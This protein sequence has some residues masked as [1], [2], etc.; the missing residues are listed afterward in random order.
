M[1]A[2]ESIAELLWLIPLIMMAIC[3]VGSFLMARGRG[4]MPCCGHKAHE[5]DNEGRQSTA[6][7]SR[8]EIEGN[9]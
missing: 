8:D 5:H 4:G 3:F 1:L 7:D 9:E 2:T 6:K